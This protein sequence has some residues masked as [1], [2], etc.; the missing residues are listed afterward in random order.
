MSTRFRRALWW[1]TC[2]LKSDSAGRVINP[3]SGDVIW[4]HGSRTTTD[5]TE[6]EPQSGTIYL[7]DS[8]AH[9]EL[10][11]CG[12]YLYPEKMT[13]E[14]AVIFECEVYAGISEIFDYR[15]LNTDIRVRQLAVSVFGQDVSS[16]DSDYEWYDNTFNG[17]AKS[18]LVG[19]GF[20]GWLEGGT[21]IDLALLWSF[22]DRVRVQGEIGV[23]REVMKKYF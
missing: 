6:T 14:T 5:P 21:Y 12:A 8:T 15:K 17:W 20:V 16:L 11:A 4:Y 23:P 22:A 1:E 13:R 9:A 7:S 19:A 10:Y 2:G 3:R 18:Q